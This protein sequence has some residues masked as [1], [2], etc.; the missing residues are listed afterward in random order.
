MYQ[1]SKS[2]T[3]IFSVSQT[4]MYLSKY[5]DILPVIDKASLKMMLK[6]STSASTVV[7]K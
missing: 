5:Y 1:N 4:N 2:H 6:T 7:L 3:S